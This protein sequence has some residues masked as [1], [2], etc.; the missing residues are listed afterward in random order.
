MSAT[1]L[2]LPPLRVLARHALPRVIEGAVIPTLLFVTLLHFGG[3]AWAIGGALV[4]SG[5]V[6]GTRLAFG[7]R[8]PTI[9]FLGLG[10]L[11]LR[12]TLALAAHSSFV[13]FLQPTVGTATV[14]IVFLASALAGKPVVLRLARDFCPLPD[15]VMAHGHLRRFFL[16]ISVLWGVVQLLNAGI[17]LWL[18]LSQSLGTF[19]VV[20]TTMANTL[21]VAAIAIS[22][23]WFR[24]IT[25]TVPEPAP[26]LAV[27]A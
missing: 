7:R 25:R 24:R 27:A 12:T 26:A 15:D 20:R 23:L 22:V 5:L 2:E 16:G 21:T 10:A 1:P 19:V 9:V 17:T 14:G 4:W 13:Y 3:Q 8:V 11:G 18:L 6:I